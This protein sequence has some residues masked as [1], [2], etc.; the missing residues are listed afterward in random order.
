VKISLGNHEARLLGK[1]LNRQ[2][3]TAR[4][5]R[6]I[7]N[8]ENVEIS[9]YE[10]MTMDSPEGP[11]A[12]IHP[13]NASVIPGRVP[14]E[15]A[16]NRFS[17]HHVIGFHGHL[18]GLT[19]STDGKRWVWDVGMCAAPLKMAYAI[20]SV[21]TRPVMVQ[22]AGII[23]EGRPHPILPNSDFTALRRMYGRAA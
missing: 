10:W 21:S 20:K 8:A 23:Y 13:K 4:F 11:W 6:M 9:S 15:I 7:T 5:K 14:A 19:K 3:R 16:R 12:I 17:D 18:W 1:A 22:G 2:V